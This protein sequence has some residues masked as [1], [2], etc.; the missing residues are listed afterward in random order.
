MFSSFKHLDVEVIN[1]LDNHPPFFKHPN[2]AVTN[3][4]SVL[5]TCNYLPTYRLKFICKFIYKWR[6][7]HIVK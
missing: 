2:V 3:E 6:F 5:A 7:I 4:L 1:V